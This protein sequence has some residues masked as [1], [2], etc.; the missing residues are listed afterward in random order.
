MGK[1]MTDRF[2]AGQTVRLNGALSRRFAAGGEYKIVRP[3]PDT[4]GERQYRIKSM[5]EPH[6]R[7]VNESDLEVA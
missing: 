5:R 4:A 7:V 2:R 1:T 3:L 6:E